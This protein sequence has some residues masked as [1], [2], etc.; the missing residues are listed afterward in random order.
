MSL[1]DARVSELSD[2]QERLARQAA[3]LLGAES[4][5]GGEET[6]EFL[7]NAYEDERAKGEGANREAMMIIEAVGMA[8][9][10]NDKRK[11]T[12]YETQ[13]KNGPGNA[14][15]KINSKTE[16][17]LA[18]TAERALQMLKDGNERFVKGKTT[19]HDFASERKANADGQ[20]PFAIVVYC[21]DSRSPAEHIFDAGVGEIFGIRTAGNILDPITLGSIEYAA[22]HL[23]TKLVVIMGHTKCGAVTA[24]CKSESA[25][26]NINAIVQKIRPIAEQNGLDVDRSISANVGAVVSETSE[27]S[28]IIQHLESK[29]LKIAGAV[30]DI[31]TGKVAFL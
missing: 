19:P 12:G 21:S 18:M 15:N 28:E 16:E 8:V 30:Y 3:S 6:L 23:E 14:L 2:E 10:E 31:E 5:F 25:P 17:V 29:G 26:G 22:E 27:K 11:Q 9:K 13:E 1:K 24:S 20:K 7:A 4:A